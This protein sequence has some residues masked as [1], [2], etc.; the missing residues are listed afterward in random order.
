MKL[1]ILIIF[2]SSLPSCSWFWSAWFLDLNCSG[3]HGITNNLLSW[4]SVFFHS[5]L[6][7]LKLVCSVVGFQVFNPKS[8]YIFS[9]YYKKPHLT[10]LSFSFSIPGPVTCIQRLT[11]PSIH[12][13]LPCRHHTSNSCRKVF[14]EGH[15]DHCWSD[16]GYI[17]HSHYNMHTNNVQLST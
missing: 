5:T 9:W 17:V 1:K 8:C 3:Q 14:F 16:I 15:A 7:K 13:D 10:A 4:I 12:S 6:K 2:F 11:N